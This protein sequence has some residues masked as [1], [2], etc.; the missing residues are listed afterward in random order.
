MQYF[1]PVVFAIRFREMARWQR[2]RK[3]LCSST[4]IFFGGIAEICA[5]FYDFP[6]KVSLH[7]S[8]YTYTKY[9]SYRGLN[10]IKQ[11]EAVWGGGVT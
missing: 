1:P 11:F 9:T 4:C 2:R 3:D 8:L 10:E 5:F 6:L 7:L